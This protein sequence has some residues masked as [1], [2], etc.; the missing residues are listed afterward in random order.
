[1]T[2][3]MRY[4]EPKISAILFCFIIF[5]SLQAQNDV[6]IHSIDEETIKE[7]L[8]LGPFSANDLD[9]DFLVDVGGERTADPKEG[10]IVVSNQGYSLT[11]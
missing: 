6:P 8:L 4:Q 7:W 5:F 2:D 9:E 3:A 10:D 1:V 11:F